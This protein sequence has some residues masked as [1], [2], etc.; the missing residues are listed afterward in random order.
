M[1]KV[2]YFLNALLG[3]LSILFSTILANAG[4]YSISGKV[5]ND[6]NCNG[7]RNAGE[8]G[9]SGVTLKLN[10]G[11]MTA[12]TGIDGTYSFNNLTSNTYEV[13]EA[14]QDGYCRTT[15]NKITVQVKN[16]NIQNQDF[17][18]SKFEVSLP[19]I[20]CCQSF[21]LIYPNNG[22]TINKPFT[23]VKGILKES[24]KEV[25]I[26]VNGVSA[27]V[28]G[29]EFVANNILL[30]EGWNTITAEATDV[31]GKKYQTSIKVYCQQTKNYIVLSSDTENGTSPLNVTLSVETYF[32]NPVI[33]SSLTCS[34]PVTPSIIKVSST[35]YNAIMSAEG[36]YRYIITITDSYG[37]KYEDSVGISVYS[38]SKMDLILKN[39]WTS[40]INSLK[41]GNTSE[42]LKQIASANQEAYKTMFEALKNQLS[43]I[44]ATATQFN[45]LS[46]T[47][48]IARYKLLTNENGKT[49]SYEVIF[50]KDNDGLWKIKKF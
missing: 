32:N 7:Q 8:D 9:I 1:K 12:T 27:E 26:I 11:S 16:K 25:G 23:M 21:S 42:A 50:V 39:K 28:F 4:T 14:E 5:F 31:D 33:N 10:P 18:N 35:E 2:K 34:G 29:N 41:Q 45:M 15:P 49:Y 47:E 24:A 38:K 13:T 30:V 48:N 44:L 40:M 20:S 37:N 17:G 3:I 22:V 6:R 46:I 36:I 43:S 19:A